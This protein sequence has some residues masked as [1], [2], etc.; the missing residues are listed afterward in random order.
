MAGAHEERRRAMST[1]VLLDTT[2]FLNILDVPDRNQK[3]DDV[4]VEFQYRIKS[5]NYF[6]LPMATIWES[7][8]FISKLKTGGLRYK[9]AKLFVDQVRDACNGDSPFVTTSFHD[10]KIF[11]TWLDAFPD[12]ACAEKSLTDLSI[13]EE[14]KQMCASELYRQAHIEIWSLDGHLTGYDR[15]P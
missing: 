4:Y 2:V 7:G 5:K 1:I 3:R 14:W 11:I 15:Q 9:F 13:I 10:N 6:F 8:N 12:S